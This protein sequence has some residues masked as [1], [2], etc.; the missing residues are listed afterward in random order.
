MTRKDYQLIAKAIAE[1]RAS[2]QVSTIGH[3]DIIQRNTALDDV[4]INIA[5]HMREDNPA[6]DLAK[7]KQAAGMK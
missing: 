1:I 6:F 4:T 5:C 3:E 7:F 2:Y